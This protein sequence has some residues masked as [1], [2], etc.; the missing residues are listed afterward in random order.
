MGGSRQN[1]QLVN[2]ILVLVA[3]LGID[4]IQRND[5]SVTI[6]ARRSRGGVKYGKVRRG[7]DDHKR[8]A[9]QFVQFIPQLSAHEL[10]EGIGV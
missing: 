10:V 7:A 6:N 1:R 3:P 9:A 4:P 5:D 8:T 2:R